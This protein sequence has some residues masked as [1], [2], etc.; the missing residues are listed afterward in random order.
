VSSEAALK[1][2]RELL[3]EI[4]GYYYGSGY[5][6]ERRAKDAI[7]LAA[8]LDAWAQEARLEARLDEAGWWH[9]QVAIAACGE[10]VKMECRER[11]AELSRP[12][13]PRRAK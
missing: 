12:R 3:K 11:I 7:I 4:P 10:D 9:V 8:A 2:A 5:D 13:P 1:R 6:S